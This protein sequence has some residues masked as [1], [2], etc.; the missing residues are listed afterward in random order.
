MLLS[1]LSKTEESLSW[2]TVDVVELVEVVDVVVTDD[3]RD[4]F[5]RGGLDA[6]L[7]EFPCVS[8][9]ASTR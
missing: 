4:L 7:L 3:G 6:W 5:L 2:A 9:N 1:F 8:T